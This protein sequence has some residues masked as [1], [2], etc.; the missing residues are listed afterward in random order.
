MILTN[1]RVNGVIRHF[2]VCKHL[3]T[4]VRSRF[5][6]F[7]WRNSS[8]FL[9][10]WISILYSRSS[11]IS[12]LCDS[13]LMKILLRIVNPS[14]L[15]FRS[16]KRSRRLSSVGH[17]IIFLKCFELVPYLV[18]KIG[19]S[20]ELASNLLEHRGQ[21]RGDIFCPLINVRF[22]FRETQGEILRGNDSLLFPFVDW[23]MSLVHGIFLG[24]RHIQNWIYWKLVIPYVPIISNFCWIVLLLRP[25]DQVHGAS[26]W[27]CIS[28]RRFRLLEVQIKEELCRIMVVE[29]TMMRDTSW[30]C[31]GYHGPPLWTRS[32]SSSAIARSPMA[33]TVSTWRCRVRDVQVVRLMWRWTL[34]KIL[35]RLAKETEITWA[36]VTSKVYNLLLSIIINFFKIMHLRMFIF[37]HTEKILLFCFKRSFFMRIKFPNIFF[38]AKFKE[39]C[40][41]LRK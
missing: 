4:R 34:R 15:G 16:F 38:N 5:A 25:I 22:T 3:K 23:R 8:K 13:R 19:F 27:L 28:V 24:R 21:S 17:F 29:I 33:R 6:G 36:I 14:R 1:C 18:N 32:W 12:D 31:A 10:L 11:D 20:H 39:T 35:K 26:V 2:A 37:L 9:S 40:K 30:R 41:Q 7:S